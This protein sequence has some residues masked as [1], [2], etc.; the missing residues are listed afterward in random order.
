[1]DSSYRH[2]TVDF[3]MRAFVC[4]LGQVVSRGQAKLAEA[5]S[6]AEGNVPGNVQKK[7]IAPR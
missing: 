6:E 7:E 1:M 4:H 2:E 3:L 5:L